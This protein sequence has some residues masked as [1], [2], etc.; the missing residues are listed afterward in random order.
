MLDG[1]RLIPQFSAA[2]IA[3]AQ[4]QYTAHTFSTPIDHFHN[5]SRYAPHS[6]GTFNMRYWFDATHYK[7][8]G[9]V[10]AL[11][12]GEDTGDDRLPFLSQGE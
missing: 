4:A 2:D 10:I 5:E 8:G 9:P 7:A 6:N 3:S 11:M 1:T 12:S